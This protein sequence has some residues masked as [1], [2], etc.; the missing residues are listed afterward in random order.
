MLF[1]ASAIGTSTAAEEKQISGTFPRMNGSYEE[2][3]QLVD[4]TERELES[5]LRTAKS[6]LESVKTALKALGAPNMDQKEIAARVQ[7]LEEM[8][9]LIREIDPVQRLVVRELSGRI[10]AADDKKVRNAVKE[11]LINADQTASLREQLG[12]LE[13]IRSSLGDAALDPAQFN[14]FLSKFGKNPKEAINHLSALK[15]QHDAM[16]AYGQLCA[17]VTRKAVY[18]FGLLLQ[19]AEEEMASLLDLVRNFYVKYASED[20]A[21]EVNRISSRLMLMFT[22]NFQISGLNPDE[23][24]KVRQRPSDI[25]GKPAQEL[26]LIQELEALYRLASRTVVKRQYRQRWDREEQILGSVMTLDTVW[27]D[28][29]QSLQTYTRDTVAIAEMLVVS[30]KK[31][32]EVVPFARVSQGV[33]ESMD[34]LQIA[35]VAAFKQMSE[36]MSKGI[37]ELTQQI[38]NEARALARDVNDRIAY[39]IRINDAALFYSFVKENI[40][41]N[42]PNSQ[43]VAPPTLWV[44]LSKFFVDL[45]GAFNTGRP[46]PEIAELK[47]KLDTEIPLLKTKLLTTK[48]DLESSQK[49]LKKRETQL[50]DVVKSHNLLVIG[51]QEAVSSI[52]SRV[53]AV[54]T[55]KKLLTDSDEDLIV[56]AVANNSLIDRNAQPVEELPGTITM[57]VL[58]LPRFKQV[59]NVFIRLLTSL[60]TQL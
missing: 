38:A 35:Q 37:S 22:G 15:N 20:V 33:L 12:Q 2:Y 5:R 25:D 48:A 32:R 50:I 1:S 28:I 57:L 44:D 27:R 46:T 17:S 49:Q 6:R 26:V 55:K 59:S 45:I 40:D 14:N 7:R 54:K 56:E 43:M 53:V 42:V 60:P 4:Q 11:I 24:M 21:K 58:S 36:R 13:D 30:P 47:N 34:K 23:M 19:M 16:V 8:T 41:R 3:K 39:V 52:A 18:H 31:A 29:M 51:A 9:R 10:D